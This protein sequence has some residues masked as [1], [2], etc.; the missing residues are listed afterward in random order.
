MVTSWKTTVVAAIMA[1]L[2]AGQAIFDAEG[3]DFQ[4][5]WM[6]LLFAVLIAG[7]GAFMKD[8]DVTG[9]GA[10]ARRVEE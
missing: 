3:F 8:S 10:S 2:V 4:K 5:D 1:A 7:L 6:Q 9:A